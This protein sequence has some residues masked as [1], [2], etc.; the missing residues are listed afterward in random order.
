MALEDVG[1]GQGASLG[2]CETSAVGSRNR[3]VILGLF[4]S[5]LSIQHQ[6]QAGLKCGSSL[7]SGRFTNGL[8]TDHSERQ[9]C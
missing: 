4:L 5:A 8:G 7:S 1:N 9:R 3:E 6:D 2:P